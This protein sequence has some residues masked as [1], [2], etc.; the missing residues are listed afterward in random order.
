MQGKRRAD[1]PHAE[2][3]LRADPAQ[4]Q[5]GASTISV[6]TKAVSGSTI[7]DPDPQVP[8]SN[9]PFNFSFSSGYEGFLGATVDGVFDSSVVGVGG[10]FDPGSLVNM[11]GMGAGVGGSATDDLE[12]QQLMGMFTTYGTGH[13]H[14]PYEGELTEQFGGGGAAGT[15]E[16]RSQQYTHVDPTQLLAKN[17]NRGGATAFQPS[18]SSDGWATGEFSSSTA[19]PEPG[20]ETT[21]SEEA[22]KKK[23]AAAVG[24]EGKMSRSVSTPDL[25]KAGAKEDGAMGASGGGEA[26]TVCTNCHTTNT[27]LWRRDPEGQPLCNACGLFYVSNGPSK[28]CRTT[29]LNAFVT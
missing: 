6:A 16:G 11:P 24:G 3:T 28:K 5:Q 26:P 23:V 20:H 10:T 27:P 13:S 4:G 18:P 8:F 1:A 2:E 19:S 15:D 22:G 9:V 29:S 21:T 7:T 14:P 17:P 25:S 12:Y